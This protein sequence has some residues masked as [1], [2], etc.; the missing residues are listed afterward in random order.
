[1]MYI[2]FYWPSTSS[3]RTTDCLAVEVKQSSSSEWV[4][5]YEVCGTMYSTSASE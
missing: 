4:R 5:I 2:Y 3:T 1:M